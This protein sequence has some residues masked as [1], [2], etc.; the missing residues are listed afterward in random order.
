M[1]CVYTCFLLNSYI[2]LQLAPYLHPN[3]LFIYR[4]FER[5]NIATCTLNPI[6]C[7]ETRKNHGKRLKKEYW[8][9][10]NENK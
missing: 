9:Q 2:L 6:F 5:L 8:V 1:C 4:H 3:N 10:V 7:K